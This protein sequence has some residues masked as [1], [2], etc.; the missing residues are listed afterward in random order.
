MSLENSLWVSY[1]PITQ[2]IPLISALTL[3]VMTHSLAHVY[4]SSSV[5]GTSVDW[6]GE[7][8][9]S[10]R[11]CCR[12]HSVQSDKSKWLP[13]SHPI[14]QTLRAKCSSVWTSQLHLLILF[15]SSFY[16][17]GIAT[18]F[19]DGL[20]AYFYIQTVCLPVYIWM[21]VGLMMI[22]FSHFSLKF[23]NLLGNN[24][25]S[26]LHGNTHPPLLFSTH[27]LLQLT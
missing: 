12:R 14:S 26:V 15:Q 18:C 9:I 22:H 7:L 6:Y 5:S 19:I 24:P 3:Y 11:Y 8:W 27:W 1:L 10:G 17:F 20:D 2:G 23:A 13:Y 4:S 25:V 16:D 21:L